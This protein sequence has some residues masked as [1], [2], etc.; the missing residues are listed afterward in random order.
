MPRNILLGYGTKAGPQ[1]WEGP[2]SYLLCTGAV[3]PYYNAKIQ[4]LPQ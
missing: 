3:E 2:L 1:E 4:A